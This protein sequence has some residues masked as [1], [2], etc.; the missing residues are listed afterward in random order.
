MD[1]SVVKHLERPEVGTL[2][3]SQAIRLGLAVVPEAS[4]YCGCALG[5]AY[6]YITGKNL[7][8]EQWKSIYKGAGYKVV[9]DMFGI[10]HEV[11]YIPS[12]GHLIEGWS[13]KKCADWLEAKGY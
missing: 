8:V 4:D 5:A 10:P 7:Q 11:V 3:L 9:A 6:T 13:R 12:R 2:K 1:E